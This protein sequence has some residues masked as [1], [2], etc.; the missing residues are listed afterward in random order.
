LDNG[1]HLLLGAYDATLALMNRLSCDPET[2]FLRLPLTLVRID[3]GFSLRAPRLPAPLHAAAALLGAKGLTLHER[4]A[5]VR[6]I[7]RLRRAG[8]QTSPGATVDCLLIAHSQPPALV[9]AL[10]RPLCIAAL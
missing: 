10:W 5:A 4:L 1:Q 6:L 9:E 8:W 7:Q 2:R 3:G